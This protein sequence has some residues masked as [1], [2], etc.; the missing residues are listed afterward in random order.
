MMFDFLSKRVALS[1]FMSL[2]LILFFYTGVRSP[3]LREYLN[4]KL[5]KKSQSYPKR[6]S[7]LTCALSIGLC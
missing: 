2:S 4:V 1:G 7:K 6:R 5:L 3:I